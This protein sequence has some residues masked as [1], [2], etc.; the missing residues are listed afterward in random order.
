MPFNQVN[1]LW[2]ASMVKI[3][4]LN[5]FA[6][7]NDWKPRMIQGVEGRFENLPKEQRVKGSKHGMASKKAS[8]IMIFFQE[9]LKSFCSS[10]RPSNSTET[11]SKRWNL[12]PSNSPSTA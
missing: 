11:S 5:D 4:R 8:F 9:F 10:K 7:G 3:I 2:I 12:Q 1:N 6:W